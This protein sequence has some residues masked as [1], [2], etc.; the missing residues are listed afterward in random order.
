MG[1]LKKSAQFLFKTFKKKKKE[2]FENINVKG[3]NNSSGRQ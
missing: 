2:Y 1:L 3:I